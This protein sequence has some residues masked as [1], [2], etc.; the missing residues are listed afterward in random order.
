M[1]NKVTGPYSNVIYTED[2]A[3]NAVWVLC[4]ACMIFF[5]QL[6]FALLECGS[7]RQKN[8]SSILIK[9]MFDACI[10][11]LG[12]WFFGFAFAFGEVNGGFI[13]YNKYFFVTNGLENFA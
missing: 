1:G 7:V 6:G 12:W 5:M 13:G 10:G 2:E 3:V 11:C 8:A 9:N 4:S